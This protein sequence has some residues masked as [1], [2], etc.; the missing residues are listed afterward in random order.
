MLATCVPPSPVLATYVPSHAVDLGDSRAAAEPLY[1]SDRACFSVFVRDAVACVLCVCVYGGMRAC[2]GGILHIYGLHLN[3]VEQ[4]H[5]SLAEHEATYLCAPSHPGVKI[6]APAC[7][8]YRDLCIT[9]ETHFTGSVSFSHPQLAARPRA[10][11]GKGKEK[12][13]AGPPRDGG[14]GSADQPSST[15]TSSAKRRRTSGVVSAGSNVSHEGSSSGDVEH[16]GVLVHGLVGQFTSDLYRGLYIID[17]RNE[18]PYFNSFHWEGVFFSVGSEPLLWKEGP[19]YATVRRYVY[20]DT[21]TR[22]CCPPTP[23]VLITR[24][25]HPGRPYRLKMWKS[26]RSGV[27]GA[28]L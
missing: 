8:A 10:F 27:R 26:M 12:N 13:G 21:R 6:L 19:L 14:K 1:I 2:G 20:A 22:R 23:S 16:T 18:S 28:G 9:K 11:P 25:G 15:G 7:L 4:I 3:M 17:T 5:R 24:V